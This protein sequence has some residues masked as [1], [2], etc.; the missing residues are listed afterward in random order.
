MGALAPRE[1]IRHQ[2]PERIVARELAAQ[3]SHAS[4]KR[5]LVISFTD[6]SRDAR[7]DRQIGFLREHYDVVTAGTARS[8]YEDVRH[9][10]LALPLFPSFYERTR[11]A[12]SLG[13]LLSRR[14]ESVYWTHPVNR[15]AVAQLADSKVDVVIANDVSALPIAC[16]VAGEGAVVLDAHEYAPAEQS[17]KFTW[18]FVIAPYVTHLLQTYIPRV[19]AAMTVSPAIA[20]LYKSN[21]GIHPTVVTNAPAAVDLTPQPVNEPIRLIHHGVADRSRRLELMVE[22]VESARG[23]FTFEMMLVPTD[24]QYFAQLQ[25]IVAKGART[26][27]VEPC[28]PR[29]IAETINC[30]DVG[31]YLLEP[32][33]LNHALALP[34]K[35]FDFI[36]A[37][38]AIAIG[39]SLEMARIVNAWECG[40]VADDFTPSALGRA[41]GSLTPDVVSRFKHRSHHAASELTAERNRDVVLELIDRAVANRRRSELGAG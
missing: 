40:V 14:Y 7:V 17:D 28:H 37:R 2:R 24:E 30:Y 13:R 15:N 23:D 25:R 35:I 12:R 36:Q 34:N 19:D 26:R 31:V 4:P 27:I 39:P 41:L 38:L 1:C 32:R 29:E 10:D 22:A 11:R 9:V 5:A 3:L 6:L 33:S 8:A 21:F 20:D 16:E 18:R